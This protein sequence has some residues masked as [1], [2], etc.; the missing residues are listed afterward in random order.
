MKPETAKIKGR[1]EDEVV[2]SFH[3]SKDM[4]NFF[5]AEDAGEA[6]FRLGFQDLEEMPIL[7]QYVDEEE[8]QRT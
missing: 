6:L 4:V 8:F 5:P 3:I 1:R 2:K 7:L